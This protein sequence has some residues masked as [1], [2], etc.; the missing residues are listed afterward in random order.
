[1]RVQDETWRTSDATS[2]GV[3]LFVLFCFVL[4]CFVLFCFVLFCFVLFCFVL[5][6]CL[7]VLFVCFF[8]CFVWNYWKILEGTIQE[9]SSHRFHLS[10]R[11]IGIE[12]SG[13]GADTNSRIICKQIEQ[14]VGGAACASCG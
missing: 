12:I 4:F 13:A 9:A 11:S 5:F 14:C 3:D 1:V 6:V 2:I 8:V 7:F 10:S